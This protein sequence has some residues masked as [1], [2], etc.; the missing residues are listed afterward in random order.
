MFSA[1]YFLSKNK[2]ELLSFINYNL[3]CS[4]FFLQF[5]LVLKPLYVAAFFCYARANKSNE[6]MMHKYIDNAKTV[7]LDLDG[8]VYQGSR[9]I[10]GAAQAIQTM[11]A[12]GKNLLYLTNSSYHSTA[13]ICLKLRRMEI[14]C[15]PN[16]IW[17]SALSATAWMDENFIDHIFCIGSDSLHRLLHDHGFRVVPHKQ[18]KAVLVGLHESF[19]YTDIMHAQYAVMYNN[20]KLIAC[21]LDQH[22]PG[23]D[24]VLMPGCGSLVAS[25]EAATGSK[26]TVNVGKP[27]VWMLDTF[28]KTYDLKVE[29]CVLIGD[30]VLSDIAMAD[31][32]GM[33]SI[34]VDHVSTLADYVGMA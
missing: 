23:N 15:E 3:K 6:V 32:A 27:S 17:T 28:R 30:S 7:I 24:G 11:R 2:I 8:V 31:R 5:E 9:A 10:K 22:Y 33:K 21:N 13:Q 14:L 25:I 19:C 18:A 29:D 12:E 26:I 4:Q 1:I 16:D 20:A 34:L